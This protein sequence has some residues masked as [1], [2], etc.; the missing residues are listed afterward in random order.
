[1]SFRTLEKAIKFEVPLINC[2]GEK[3]P[4][5]GSGGGIIRAQ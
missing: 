5:K 1:M 4:K 3:K 2:R